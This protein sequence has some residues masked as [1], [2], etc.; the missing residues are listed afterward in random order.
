MLHVE[1]SYRVVAGSSDLRLAFSH[2]NRVTFA[3]FYTDCI[4]HSGCTCPVKSL[5]QNVCSRICSIARNKGAHYMP[6]REL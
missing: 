6:M 2:A 5:E 1:G 4:Q 3:F